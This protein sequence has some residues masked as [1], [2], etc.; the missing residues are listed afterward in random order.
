[1]QP[2]RL[3]LLLSRP[4]ESLPNLLITAGFHYFLRGLVPILFEWNL[5]LNL[6][7]LI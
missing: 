4:L 2:S 5:Q 7:R 6:V 3:P 1:M